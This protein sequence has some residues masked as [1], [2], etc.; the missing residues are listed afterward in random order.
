MK[1]NPVYYQTYNYSVTQNQQQKLNNHNSNYTYK[2]IQ[3]GAFMF[4][5]SA[6][7][8]DKVKNLGKKAVDKTKETFSDFSSLFQ[9]ICLLQTPQLHKIHRCWY[10]PVPLQSF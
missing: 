7:M 3:K 1:I 10:S 8:W 2:Y 5:G 9:K 4:T 6:N